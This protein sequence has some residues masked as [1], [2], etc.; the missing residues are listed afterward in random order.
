M[1]AQYITL[2]AEFH[3]LCQSLGRPITIHAMKVRE[4]RF[5]LLE[6]ERIERSLKK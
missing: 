4:F 2:L 3:A 1:P 6:K 5:Y